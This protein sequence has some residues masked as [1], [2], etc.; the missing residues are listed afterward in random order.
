MGEQE[1]KLMEACENFIS[2]QYDSSGWCR[3]REEFCQ[4]AEHLDA[5]Q[6][7]LGVGGTCSSASEGLELIAEGEHEDED[8]GRENHPPVIAHEETAYF[9]ILKII[10]LFLIGNNCTGDCFCYLSHKAIEI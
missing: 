4:L 8:E 5:M 2:E 6:Q 7:H 3:L 9:C 1:V 10:Q